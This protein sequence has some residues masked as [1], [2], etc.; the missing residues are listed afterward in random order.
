MSWARRHV[1]DRFVKAAQSDKLVA[2]SSYKLTHLASK[3]PFLF[4]PRRAAV[5]DVGAAPGSWLQVSVSTVFSATIAFD[6]LSAN[7][8]MLLGD[9]STATEAETV[10]SCRRRSAAAR[11]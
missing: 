1:T 11:R 4:K 3:F 2:R 10:G 8:L 7:L 5:L 9:A 6:T